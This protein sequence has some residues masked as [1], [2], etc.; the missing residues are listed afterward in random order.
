MIVPILSPDFC[1]SEWDQIERT[2]AML[3][4]PS[5]LGRRMR[6]LLRRSCKPPRFLKVLNYIDVTTDASFDKEYRR[7]C[8]DLDG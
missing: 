1:K 3:D 2:S 5:G 6:P 7:I 8:R 4:E